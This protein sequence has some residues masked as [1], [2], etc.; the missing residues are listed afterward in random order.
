MLR[1][2][3]LIL[4][5]VVTIGA[6]T[7]AEFRRTA[8]WLN[9]QPIIAEVA[10]SPAAR[11]KGLMG[12]KTLA[13]DQGMLFVQETPEKMCFW[14]KDT[15]MALSIAFL[16]DHGEVLAVAE[17]APMSRDHHCSPV[18]VRHALEMPGGWFLQHGAKAGSRL[19]GAAFVP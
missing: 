11:S 4:L 13:Q 8:L 9:G 15:P 10:S 17:M 6:S 5:T 3:A 1:S 2:G 7:Q 16:D 18:P 14:M 12:R 19:T